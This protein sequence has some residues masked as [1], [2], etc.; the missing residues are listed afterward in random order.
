MPMIGFEPGS[1]GYKAAALPS[2]LS[3]LFTV[4]H[5]L[6][7]NGFNNLAPGHVIRL[8]AK[9]SPDARK[10]CSGV[11]FSPQIQ[12]QRGDLQNLIQDPDKEILLPKIQSG[13]M[14][15]YQPI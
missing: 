11:H 15:N 7:V 6:I 14:E 2:V 4:F 8:P 10:N 12:L 5:F 1:S 9:R 13:K 3:H